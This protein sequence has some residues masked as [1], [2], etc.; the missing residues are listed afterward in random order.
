MFLVVFYAGIV[1]GISLLGGI[2]LEI[3]SMKYPITWLLCVLVI[4]GCSS[5]ISNAE[6]PLNEG[7][8]LPHEENGHAPLDKL[9]DTSWIL[10]SMEDQE[11]LEKTQ[12]TL[13]I[14]TTRF[15]GSAGCNEYEMTYIAKTSNSYTTDF[16]QIT[17]EACQEPEGILEQERRFMEL[18]R[19]SESFH[20]TDTELSLINDQGKSIL[21]FRTDQR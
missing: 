18:L 7:N 9:I 3:E 6:A 5:E 2:K 14:S 11:P 17:V 8:L 15:L 4:T 1:W 10:S 21:V 19:S 20:I 12:I 16:M 13:Q